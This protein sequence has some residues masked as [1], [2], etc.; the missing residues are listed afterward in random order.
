M[1]FTTDIENVTKN[2]N[3]FRQNYI[4]KV[5]LLLTLKIINLVLM[6]FWNLWRFWGTAIA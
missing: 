3:L 4:L 2:K 5:L 1:N 6:K